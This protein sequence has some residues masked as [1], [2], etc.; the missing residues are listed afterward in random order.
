MEDS[1]STIRNPPP[2]ASAS[3]FADTAPA[4]AKKPNELTRSPSSSGEDAGRERLKR[5]RNEVAGKVKIPDK[6]GKEQ[7]MKDWTEFSTFDG[8]LG[9]HRMIIA[10]RDALIAD[11]RKAKSP[12]LRIH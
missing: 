4:E 10:A 7:M 1:R 5:H 6:W 3:L 8:L 11:A 12:R 9:S 2:P